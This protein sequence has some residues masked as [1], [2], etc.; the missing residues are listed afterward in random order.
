[1][2]ASDWDIALP[3]CSYPT[4]SLRDEPFLRPPP[5]APRY[6]P[7]DFLAP[8]PPRP[9]LD[10]IFARYRSPTPPE[11]APGVRAD[12]VLTARHPLVDAFIAALPHTSP[13]DGRKPPREAWWTK[14]IRGLTVRDVLALDADLSELHSECIFA[15]AALRLLYHFHH[16]AHFTLWNREEMPRTARRVQKLLCEYRL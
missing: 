3:S 2:P 5:D 15:L 1:M 7:Y 16:P 13:R 12:G 8:E 10:P 4:S 11:V 6:D 14:R 9:S